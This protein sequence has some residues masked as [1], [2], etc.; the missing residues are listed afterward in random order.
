MITKKNRSDFD[1]KTQ[2]R[3][4]R[5]FGPDMRNRIGRF[6]ALKT[7]VMNIVKCLV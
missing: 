4:N 3:G 6:S 7:L 2:I 1:V 5:I